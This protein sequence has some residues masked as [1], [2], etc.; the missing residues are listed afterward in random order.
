MRVHLRQ[1]NM[2][3]RE[4]DQVQYYLQGVPGVVRALSLFDY[5]TSIVEVPDHTGREIKREY[6]DRMFWHIARRAV[7]KFFLPVPVRTFVT[8]VKAVPFVWNGIRSL[9]SGVSTCTSLTVRR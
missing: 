9:A 5:E 2:T 1:C 6:E 3:C 8:Q 7:T 4:A